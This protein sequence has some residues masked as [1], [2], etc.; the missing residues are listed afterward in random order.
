MATYQRAKVTSDTANLVLEDLVVKAGLE[1]T[2]PCG[3]GGDIHRRL[4]TAQNDKVL[5][6][7]DGGTV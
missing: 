4:T 1:F 6:G 3:S 5:L 2:L 7:C